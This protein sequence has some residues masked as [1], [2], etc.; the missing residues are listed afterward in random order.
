MA[1]NTRNRSSHIPLRVRAEQGEVAVL[2]VILLGLLHGCDTARLKLLSTE[3]HV[4]RV[5]NGTREIA[6][7]GSFLYPGLYACAINEE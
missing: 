2:P 1:K 4:A 6:V 5:P 7:K 3:T